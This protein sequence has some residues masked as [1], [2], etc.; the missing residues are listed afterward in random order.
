MVQREQSFLGGSFPR[1]QFLAVPFI[2]I[3][4]V[5]IAGGFIARRK[6]GPVQDMP[7]NPSAA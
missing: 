7:T 5:I 2:A 6:Q 4:L 1:S 3:N